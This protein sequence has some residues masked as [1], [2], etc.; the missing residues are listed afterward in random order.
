LARH[1]FCASECGRGECGRTEGGL[2]VLVIGSGGREHALVWRLRQSQRVRELYCVPGNAGIA[3]DAECLAGDVRDINGLA[4]LADR[5][6]ADLTVVGPELPLTLGIADEFHRRRLAIIGPTRAAAELEGSKV[7]AKRFLERHKIPTAFF[8]VCDSSQ[9][10]YAALCS[11]EFPVVLKA[12]GLAS[13]KGVIIAHTADEATATVERIMEQ[14]VFGAAGDRIVIEEHLE[15]EELS[16]IVLTDGKSV[17][18]LASTRDHKPVFDGDQGPNTGGMGAYCDDS[19][20]A[21]ELQKEILQTIVAPTIQGMALEG[22][23]YQ[24]FLYFGLMLTRQGPRVLEFNCRPGDPEMQPQVLRMD[25]DLVDV[26]EKLLAG[27]LLEARMPWWEGSSVCVVLASKGYPGEAETGKVIEGLAAAEGLAGIKV[28][29]AGT[30]EVEGKLVTSGGRVLGVTARAGELRTAIELCYQAVSRIRF[31]GMHY[32]RDI[33][34]RP[35][36]FGARGLP[37][38]FVA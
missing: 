15:G 32:R 22:R 7:F 31:D 13:G 3:R 19:I 26:L 9:D 27:R 25:F 33:G 30:K 4:N 20:I 10:A 29:H 35:D 34:A 1:S 12:D 8:A 38:G 16:F 17:Q 23:P 11:F 2:K 37:R 5:L 36:K 24:G 28:F 18:P 14:H 21:P 6:K